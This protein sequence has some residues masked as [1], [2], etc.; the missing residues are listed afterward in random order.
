MKLEKIFVYGTLKNLDFLKERFG[1]V[2]KKV[3]DAS[4]RGRLYDCKYFPVLLE[5]E[6]E[7]FGKLLT[8]SELKE[9]ETLFDS[10]EGI[11]RN[12]IYLRKRVRVF[13]RDSEDEAYVYV[14]NPR[15]EFIKRFCKKKNFIKEGIWD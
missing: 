15:N 14:G 6:G 2:P 13:L 12:G 11:S 1:I 4:V 10:F 7:V 9:D 3:E 8:I 5:E